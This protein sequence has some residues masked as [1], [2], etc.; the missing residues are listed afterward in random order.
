M[1]DMLTLG[2]PNFNPS[3]ISMDYEKGLMNDFGAYFPSAQIHGCF[4]HLVQ[5]MKRQ[6]A[7]NGLSGRYRNELWVLK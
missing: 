3:A 1:L 6:V 5:N 7:A 4:F 2:W